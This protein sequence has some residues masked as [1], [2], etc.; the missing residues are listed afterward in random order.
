[1]IKNNLW[2]AKLVHDTAGLGRTYCSTLLPR[3]ARGN[4]MRYARGAMKH[5]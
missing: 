1:L 5:P 2:V 3:L 4:N